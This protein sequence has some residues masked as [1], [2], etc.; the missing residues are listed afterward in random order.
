MASPQVSHA[1]FPFKSNLASPQAS[2][3]PFII[4]SK[5]LGDSVKG[6]SFFEIRWQ[7]QRCIYNF[8]LCARP[9]AAATVIINNT[10][11]SHSHK[12]HLTKQ[13]NTFKMRVRYHINSITVHIVSLKENVDSRAS[14][15][16]KWVKLLDL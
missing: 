8:H 15:R 13:I 2:H 3:L 14:N 10:S 12:S 5:S 16:I 4:K 7:Q 1:L 11:L 6:Y 9:C